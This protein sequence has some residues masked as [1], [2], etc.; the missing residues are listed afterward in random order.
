MQIPKLPDGIGAALCNLIHAIMSH[1]PAAIAIAADDNPATGASEVISQARAVDK[2]NVVAAFAK[3]PPKLETPPVPELVEQ[4]ALA[5]SGFTQAEL[6]EAGYLVRVLPPAIPGAAAAT[7]QDQDTGSTSTPAATQDEQQNAGAHVKQA[8]FLD[9]GGIPWDERIH[10][11]G[12]TRTAN[13][14]W[15]KR[16]NLP[17][18]E[19]DRITEELRVANLEPFTPLAKPT[20]PPPPAAKGKPTPSPPPA[21]KAAAASPAMDGKYPLE[22]E[23]TNKGFA[24]FCQY[25]LDKTL[26]KPSAAQQAEIYEQFG[27]KGIGS[28]GS[29]DNHHLIDPVYQ[30]WRSAVA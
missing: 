27:L 24:A 1:Q 4:D 28:L 16:K 14:L 9:E 11:G 18:G 8:A 5:E 22:L 12:R 15:T 25:T 30:A 20:A 29:V 21:A 6:R 23:A 2:S 13:G 19:Y 3:L 7:H 26:P 10:S 17:T